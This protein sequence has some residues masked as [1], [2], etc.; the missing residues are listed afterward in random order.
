MLEKTNA[1]YKHSIELILGIFLQL[2]LTSMLATFEDIKHKEE[3]TIFRKSRRNELMENRRVYLKPV[4]KKYSTE[5][6]DTHSELSSLSESQ[7]I[8]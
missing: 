4:D 8:L 3:S 1:F 6:S 5:F 7:L 2:H